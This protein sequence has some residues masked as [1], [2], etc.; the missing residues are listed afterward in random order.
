[1]KKNNSLNKTKG[2]LRNNRYLFLIIFIFILMILDAVTENLKGV[3]L[4]IFK[5]DFNLNDGVMGVW[6]FIGSFGYIVFTY[7]GGLFSKKVGQKK[8]IIS[9]IILC[10][11]STFLFSVSYTSRVMLF[12]DIFLINGSLALCTIAI[13]TLIPIIGIG[14]QAILMNLTHFFYGFGVTAGTWTT[15]YL[16]GKNV[17]W[18]K[19]Y[20][21]V[22]IL[23]VI[24]GVIAYFIK[25]PNVALVE[26]N[27]HK[28]KSKSIFK[29][30]LLYAFS[31]T[32][33]FY[34]FAECATINWLVNYCG[35]S[36]GLSIGQA[37]KYLTIFT[38]IFTVGRLVG[39][40]V[41]QK[42]GELKSVIVST[43]TAIVLFLSGI[44]LGQRGII[45]ISISGLFFAITY[46]TMILS[47]SE[48]FKEESSYAMGVIVSMASGVNM[49]F[50]VVLGSLNQMMGATKG[51]LI[52]PISLFISLCAQ[53]YIKNSCR[54]K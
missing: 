39:G 24:I 3:F 31:V 27:K 21:S 37:T 20:F 54:S 18:Q 15:G 48:V 33:G 42:F 35:K 26:E 23:Y 47:S 36:F 8:V 49:I 45:L 34:V 12:I 40:F 10:I 46:P 13:N 51:F 4:P 41:V 30:K 14:F 28:D 44:L 50:N 16:L 25:V 22:G 9:G 17:P 38:A 7:L 53:I 32:L 52:I 2:K 1:M 5:N 11:I 19:I 6:L 43:I 29:D